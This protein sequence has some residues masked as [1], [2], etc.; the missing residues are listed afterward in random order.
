MA[1]PRLE[2]E[3]SVEQNL[4]TSLAVLDEQLKTLTK[5]IDELR[6]D[7]KELKDI[8]TQKLSDHDRRISLAEEKL[9]RLNWIVNLI[10][11]ALLTGLV[12]GVLSLIFNS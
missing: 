11:G 1:T 2:L 3:Q 8:Q 10:T 4:V 7:I 12:G 6:Q 5:H 9:N